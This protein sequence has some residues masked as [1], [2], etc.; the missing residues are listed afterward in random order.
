MSDVAARSF[1]EAM[2]KDW[3]DA[4]RNR[5]AVAY[6]DLMWVVFRVNYKSGVSVVLKCKREGMAHEMADKFND[7]YEEGEIF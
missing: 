7:M 2:G 1:K 4:N 5:F 6:Y 3:L